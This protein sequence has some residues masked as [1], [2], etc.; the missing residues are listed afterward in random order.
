MTI[1]S[2]EA[3]IHSVLARLGVSILSAHTLAFGNIYGVKV[4]NV[5]SLPI[6]PDGHSRGLASAPYPRLPRF[7]QLCASRRA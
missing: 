2:N 7:F 3:I 5:E 4:I 6:K 1:A